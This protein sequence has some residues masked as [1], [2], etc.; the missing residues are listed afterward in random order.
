MVNTKAIVEMVNVKGVLV[1]K[2][3]ETS[4]NGVIRFI[5]NRDLAKGYYFLF[6]RVPQQTQCFGLLKS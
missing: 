3:I 5:M 6:V 4:V 2:S 1:I